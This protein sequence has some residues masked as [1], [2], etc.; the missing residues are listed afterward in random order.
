MVDQGPSLRNISSFPVQV[1]KKKVHAIVPNQIPAF[2]LRET[3]RREEIDPRTYV[4]VGDSEACLS[5]IITLR[6]SFMGRIIVVPTSANGGFENKDVLT[7]K[8]GPLNK[9]E[10]FMVE[11]DLFEKA[12]VEV[13]KEGIKKINHE[14]RTVEFKDGD[15]CD[16]EGI[17]F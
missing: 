6:F 13:K 5:A 8:F 11:P 16:F 14:S 2:S 4:L 3:L 9:S 17:L 7:R 1:R 12:C 10:V 15:E